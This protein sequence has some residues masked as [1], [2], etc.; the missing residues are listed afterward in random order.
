LAVVG[1]A[2]LASAATVYL[3]YRQY[4][5]AVAQYT[6][7]SEQLTGQYAFANDRLTLLQGQQKFFQGLSNKTGRLASFELVVSALSDE[8][9]IALKDAKLMWPAVALPGVAPASGYQPDFE[10]VIEVPQ[11]STITALAQSEPL[12][13][14]LSLKLGMSLRLASGSLQTATVAVATPNA[15]R[16]YRIQGEL[17][18]R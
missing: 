7:E 13:T 6:A 8:P 14:R 5:L 12:I 18:A 3:P 15:L 4:Q 16:T 10:V 17:R 9:T 2:T 11:D 1:L